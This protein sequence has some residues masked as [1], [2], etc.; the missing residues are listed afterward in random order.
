MCLYVLCACLCEQVEARLRQLEGK[1][2][3]SE[4]AKPRGLPSVQKYEPLRQG[5]A[6]EALLSQ[7]KAYNADADVA[8]PD[9]EG[10]K[11]KKKVGVAVWVCV[12]SVFGSSRPSGC[13]RPGTGAC[14]RLGPCPLQKKAEEEPAAAAAA[15]DANGAADPSEKVG[16]SRHALVHRWSRNLNASFVPCHRQYVLD[17]SYH[18][19]AVLQKKKKKKRSAEEAAGAEDGAAAAAGEGEKKVRL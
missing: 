10:K 6:G 4:A 8:L 11:K 15:A 14:H 2:L 17:S 18:L 12:C 1:Q 9:A 19:A 7:P 5:D 13:A 3:G 16:V